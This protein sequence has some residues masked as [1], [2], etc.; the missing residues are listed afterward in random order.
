M[1][2]NLVQACSYTSNVQNIFSSRAIGHLMFTIILHKRSSVS[3][4]NEE[5]V[6]DT[7]N[8]ILKI[9]D[10]S[11]DSPNFIITFCVNKVQLMQNSSG[12]YFSIF[13]TYSDSSCWADH[14]YHL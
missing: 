14:E 6:S 13:H 8:F 1:K 12:F 2:T 4:V 3:S 7:R 11:Q 9:R 5:E 10:S